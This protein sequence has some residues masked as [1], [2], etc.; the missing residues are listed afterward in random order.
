[1]SGARRSVAT[2]SPWEDS[3]GYS[4]VVAIGGRAWVSGT[5]AA[6]AQRDG[7]TVPESAAEQTEIA[8]DVAL[9]AL[10]QVGFSASDVVRTR[11]YLTDLEDAQGVGA[12]HARVLG[13]VRPAA[14]LV[15]VK[16]LIDRRLKVEV[17]LEAAK[18]ARS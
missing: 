14:T 7:G 12:V 17:E 11:L 13:A 5:T 8:L 2:G 4:R 3:F 6:S 16:S 18:A 1:M 10:Q 15:C 9:D